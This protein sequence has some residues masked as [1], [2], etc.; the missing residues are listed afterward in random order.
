V[1]G[2]LP[3]FYEVVGVPGAG[4]TTFVRNMA[5]RAAKGRFVELD[6]ALVAALARQSPKALRIP[7]SDRKASGA[8]NPYK[9]FI[10]AHFYGS[11]A[12]FES[13]VDF[14][15]GHDRYVQT[16]IDAVAETS[17]AEARRLMLAWLFNLFAKYQYVA[18]SS[19]SDGQILVDEGFVGR[20]VTLFAYRETIPPAEAIRA[21]VEAA[22]KPEAV[23]RLNAS[24]A[25]CHAR[26]T[27]RPKGPPTRFRSLSQEQQF[28]T[29]ENCRRCI[30]I[31]LEELSKSGVR[32]VDIDSE[33]DP[34][35]Q[36]ATALSA[37]AP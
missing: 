12:R 35:D 13:L 37:F 18:T 2:S 29:L 31:A 17:D 30:E 5:S 34:K 23:I 27:G 14:V 4:K 28:Q 24:L 19:K 21:Y 20:V 3:K 9:S 10:G 1:K 26:L 16:V 32:I 8:D 6:A 7:A 33:R 25:E 11:V 22:P 15:T 36:V